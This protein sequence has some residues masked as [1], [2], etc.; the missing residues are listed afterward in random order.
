MEYV[1]K[2]LLIMV[3]VTVIIAISVF[4]IMLFLS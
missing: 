3:E 4:F 1:M 2:G